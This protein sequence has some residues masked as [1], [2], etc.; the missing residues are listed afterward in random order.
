MTARS[1]ITAMVMLG[2]AE[3]AAELER[4]LDAFRD[5]AWREVLGDDLNP[6][7][8]VLNAESYRRLRAR[9]EATMTAEWDGDADEGELL[10]RYVEHLA[11]RPEREAVL[12][13]AADFLHDAHFGDGLSVQEIGTAMRHWANRTERGDR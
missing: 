4:C 12:R 13:E 1:R 2:T 3:R 8:L 11:A 5:E 6:S 7:A 9:I 10:A